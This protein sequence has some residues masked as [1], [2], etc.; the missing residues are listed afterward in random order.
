MKGGTYTLFHWRTLITGSKLYRVQYADE[1][2]IPQAE[3]NFSAL[4]SFLLDR[5]AVPDA[6]GLRML[7]V[8]GLWTPAGTTLLLS[9]NGTY[10]CLRV[11]VPS[12]S[13]GVL[14]LGLW[15]ERDW[16]YRRGGRELWVGWMRVELGVEDVEDIVEVEDE[17]KVREKEMDKTGAEEE[18][19]S[20]KAEETDHHHI[21]PNGAQGTKTSQASSS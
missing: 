18:K 8:S 16:D 6:Q 13:D 12:D 20:T 3:I 4:I 7:S 14:S 17:E 15:W 9:P 10:S 21:L 19:R 11:E 5:G 1:L 2:E